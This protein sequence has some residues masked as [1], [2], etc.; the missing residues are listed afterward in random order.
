MPRSR[1]EV[2]RLA[3]LLTCLALATS[4]I[5]LVAHELV[6]HGG[7]AL[8][9]GAHITGVRLF[10]FAGG[11]IHYYLADG[12]LAAWLA[13][14][15]GGIAVELACG[16]AILLAARGDSF[17]RR[18]VRGIGAALVLHGSW[19][20]ATGAWSGFGDGQ[21]LY[22]VLG[23]ARYPVAIAAGAITCTA[24]FVGARNVFG[25]IAGTLADR[26]TLGV[27]VAAAIAAAVN[28]GLAVGE[29]HVRR[30]PAYAQIMQ[31]ER[32]RVVTRELATWTRDQGSAIDEA[33]LAAQR[34]KLEDEQRTFPFAW[35]LAVCTAIAALGGARRSRPGESAALPLRAAALAAAISIGGVI[36][37]SY[38]T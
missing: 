35:L 4:R 27:I 32:E 28:V 1:I 38:V 9:V 3:A 15:M 17:G 18:I 36:A 13:I 10:W 23:D 14:A 25:A 20:L 24:A 16:T 30:D 33:A 21:L 37:L 11:W 19:Y 34:A 26:R 8:A 5:G 12:S 7:T 31:P 22:R 2:F 29:L 6:G